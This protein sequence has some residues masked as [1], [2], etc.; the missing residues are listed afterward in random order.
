[1]E[2]QGVVLDPEGL[3]TKPLIAWMPAAC[4]LLFTFICTFP[5]D[6]RPVQTGLDSSWMYGLSYLTGSNYVF[7]RDVVFTY[8]PLGFLL[9]P[10]PVS[11]SLAIGIAFWSGLHLLFFGSLTVVLRRMPQRLALF[12]GC[13]ILLI[14][15][16]LW[17]EYQLLA[18]IGGLVVATIEE[19]SVS[20]WFAAAAGIL[21]SVAL[22]MKWSLGISAL[23]LLAGSWALLYWMPYVGALRT[24]FA[25]II[26]FVSG[27][28]VATIL[29][30]QS[31]V[32]LWRWI[33]YSSE[34][35]SGYSAAMSLEGSVA[36]LYLAGISATIL[37]VLA[38][39]LRPRARAVLLLFGIYA[40]VAFKHGFV[41][42]GGHSMA[43][44]SAVCM[45]PAL[46]LVLPSLPV[47]DVRRL[48]L[49][50]TAL[51]VVGFIYGVNFPSFPAPNWANFSALIGLRSG[52]DNLD[53]FIHFSNLQ[54][55]LQIQSTRAVRSDVLPQSWVERIGRS[56]VTVMPWELSV[57]AANPIRLQPLPTLQLY[58]AYTA[59]L[60]QKTADE[61]SQHGAEYLI[62]S[63]ENIDG[64]NL[65]LDTPATWRA[66]I[67]N[68]KIVEADTIRQ[69]T[70]LS[71]KIRDVKSMSQIASGQARSGEWIAVPVT[72]S[73]LYASLNLEY[74]FSGQVGR[75][76]YQVPPVS[77]ELVRSS[78]RTQRCRLLSETAINGIMINYL[79][80]SQGEFEDLLEGYA[81]DPVTRFRVI[82][83]PGHFEG[84][85]EWRILAS[86]ARIVH[87]PADQ[88][89]PELT[90]FAAVDRHDGEFLFR[91]T[92]SDANGSR[93]NR[94]VQLIVNR[95]F[96]G[97]NACYLSYEVPLDRLWLI[98]DKGSGPAGVSRFGEPATLANSQCTVSM[99]KVFARRLHDSIALD[100]PI[101]FRASFSGSRQAF[102]EVIDN[103]GLHRSFQ[104][105]ARLEIQ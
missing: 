99:E 96:N 61:L 15:L 45:I 80:T 79:P 17:R 6:Y 41:R 36:V 68:Y 34:I 92:V 8:G 86:S 74:S 102:V 60:D 70:L 65:F 46:V 53:A 101:S 89:P 51:L 43:Y 11:H 91:M 57:G 62:V 100:V 75:A 20:P 12:C 9:N 90:S 95:E 72:D 63:F 84:Q 49:G 105:H 48:F 3:K 88:K 40:M 93:D 58:S 13:Y 16:G 50:F 22:L 19:G 4:F 67:A 78:G 103:E 26:A 77:L 81:D 30:F 18:V 66:I 82:E 98:A 64:R 52:P 5:G 104:P 23:S 44:F 87:P 35:A 39:S 14:S 10:L 28:A 1:M 7:G 71:R 83:P 54:A 94:F 56:T 42:Q 2:P 21:G 29:V 76:L 32:N 55:G 97:V 85:Y 73:F 69:R 27:I 31:P 38:Y 33:R 25:G 47:Y 37:V 59:S 24:T